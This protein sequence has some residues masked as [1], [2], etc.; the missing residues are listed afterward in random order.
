M[1]LEKFSTNTLPPYPD[2]WKFCESQPEMTQP[3][4]QTVECAMPHAPGLTIPLGWSAQETVFE[5]NWEAIT[6]ELYVE[7]DQIDLESFGWTTPYKPSISEGIKTRIW[8]VCLKDLSPGK[9]TL[10]LVWTFKTSINDG[11]YTYQAGT[12]EQILNLTVSEK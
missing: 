2:L 11:T 3:A 10:R 5:A 6:W 7:G 9:L 4:T 1:T 8:V 12:Y